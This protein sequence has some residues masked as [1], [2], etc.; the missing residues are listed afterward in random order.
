MPKS[1]L[2]KGAYQENPK[3]LN[4]KVP[5]DFKKQKAQKGHQRM[6]QDHK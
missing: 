6:K 1:T 2:C 5:A 3:Q 4:K